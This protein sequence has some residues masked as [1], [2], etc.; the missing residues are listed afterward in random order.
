MKYGGVS[1]AV[2]VPDLKDPISKEILNALFEKNGQNTSQ[3]TDV[4]RGRRGSASRRIIRQKL[5]HL[6]VAGYVLKK[7]TKKS[8]EY[9][10]SEELVK[11]WSQV[12]GFNK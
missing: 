11:K 10:I 6:E 4:V 7:K 1:P 3:I 12:L 9:Y 2:I 5:E 8:V